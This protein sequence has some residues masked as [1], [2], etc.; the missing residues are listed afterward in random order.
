VQTV[1]GLTCI[2]FPAI[3]RRY[4]VQFTEMEHHSTPLSARSLGT[5]RTPR[6]NQNILH[7]INLLNAEQNPICHLLALLGAHLILYVS[8]V[9]VN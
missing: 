7:D 5:Q 1:V 4:V 9:R 8:R 2:P 3:R 6:V